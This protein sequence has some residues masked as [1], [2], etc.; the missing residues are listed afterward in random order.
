[1]FE[2]LLDAAVDRQGQRRAAGRRIGEIG[3]ERPL[4]AGNAMAVDVGVAKD[5]R[6]EA[7]LGIEA[8]GLTLDRQAGLAQRVDRF[9][10]AR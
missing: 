4:H 5:V 2:R 1:M 9:D 10:Q 3:V 7:G 8:V 6:G